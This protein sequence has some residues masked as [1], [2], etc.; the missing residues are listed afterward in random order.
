V[1]GV[2]F[3][4]MC[5]AVSMVFG[6]IWGGLIYWLHPVAG[7][8]IG[9]TLAILCFMVLFNTGREHEERVQHN[10]RFNDA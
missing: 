5:L 9:G 10:R 1:S 3:L 8:L 4:L 6:G 7:L 2:V